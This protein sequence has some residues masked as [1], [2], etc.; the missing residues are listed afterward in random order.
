MV[1]MVNLCNTILLFIYALRVHL[2]HHENPN[3]L[4]PY[5]YKRTTYLEWGI[6]VCIFLQ[7]IICFMFVHPTD[8]VEV[9]TY[10]TNNHLCKVNKCGYPYTLCRSWISHK[11]LFGSHSARYFQAHF[12]NLMNA[13]IVCTRKHQYKSM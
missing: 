7:L 3:G 1:H 12:V 11:S 5:L 2:L 13:S 6:D 4:V 10:S 9:R 8:Y